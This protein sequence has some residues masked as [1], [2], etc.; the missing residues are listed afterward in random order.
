M[1][2]EY[3]FWKGDNITSMTGNNIFVYGANPVL[4]LSNIV[5]LIVQY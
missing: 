5:H 3:R 2:Q 1:S 4:S